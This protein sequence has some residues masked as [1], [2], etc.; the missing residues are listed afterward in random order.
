MDCNRFTSWTV[1]GLP[2]GHAGRSRDVQAEV[3]HRRGGQ[4]QSRGSL[5]WWVLNTLTSEQT[6][7]LV[8]S[9]RWYQSKKGH[10]C[11]RHFDIRTN[12]VSV[13]NTLISEQTRSPV[14]STRW[15]QNK[16]GHQCVQHFDIRTS[17]VNSVFNMLISEQTRSPVRSTLWQQNK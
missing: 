10:Q 8:C 4:G 3:I 14:C 6:R 15:Y 7:S 2:D 1:T 11:V 16:Q 12:K 5:H 17:K 9:T 13:L